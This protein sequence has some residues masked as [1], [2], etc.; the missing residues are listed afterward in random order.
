MKKNIYLM[1]AYAFFQGMVFYAPV[2][3]LYRKACGVSFFQIT[4]MESISLALML[5]LEIPW[6]II[7]DK[8]GYKKTIVFCSS[9]FFISKLVFW[10]ADSFGWFL[11]E[12]ILLSVVLAGLS[13]VDTS[14]LYLSCQKDDIS[15]K[16]FGIYDSMG[17][18]GLLISSAIFALFIKD[19]YHMAAYLTCISYGLA[20]FF[21]FFLD[22]VKIGQ[23]QLEDEK[24]KDTFKKTFSSKSLILFLIGA[25]LLSETYQTVITFLSQLKY[26]KCGLENSIIGYV[27]TLATVAGLFGVFSAPL[28]KKLGNKY[29]LQLFSAASVISCIVLA[30]TN[31]A[32]LSVIGVLLLCV[33]QSLFEPFSWEIQQRQVKAKNRAAS[34]SINAMLMNCIKIASDLIFG[35]LSNIG[36]FASFYFGAAISLLSLIIFYVWCKTYKIKR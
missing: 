32:A 31:S 35:A 27:Y 9:L 4:L 17:T 16:V 19:D 10:K 5:I 20:A 13:G 30:V 7:A 3:A 15:Q 6:G 2:S 36:L 8:I 24:F 28:T 23:T 25:A 26:Q 12:R 14:F 11:I 22:E 21:T 29:S 34:L 18:A 33:A 1:Y